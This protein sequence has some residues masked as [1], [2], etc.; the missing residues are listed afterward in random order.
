[1][2]STVVAAALRLVLSA[3]LALS[4]AVHAYLYVDGY[5]DIPMIGQAFLGQAVVFCVLALLILAGGPDWL[6]WLAGMVSAGALVA[7]ALSRTVGLFGFTELG[8][9]PSPQAAVSVMAEVL[10]VVFAAVSVLSNRTKPEP[11]Q[12]RSHQAA[13]D[14]VQRS[15]SG[16][17]LAIIG[18]RVVVACPQH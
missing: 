16:E 4:G 12:Q 5:R 13:G 3:S 14:A 18:G 7:F 2:R 9:N 1:M 10:T 8:W 11:S 6:R 17:S 15:S